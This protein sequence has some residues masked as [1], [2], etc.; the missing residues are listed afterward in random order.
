MRLLIVDDDLELLETLVSALNKHYII[1]T[2][3]TY[4]QGEYLAITNDYDLLILDFNLPDGNGV[5]LCQFLRKDNCRVPILML[6]GRSEVA[7]KVIALDKGVDDYLLKPFSSQ[8]LLARIRALLRRQPL[9]V[10]QTELVLHDL[11]INLATGEVLQNNEPINLRP[12]EFQILEFLVRNRGQI[13]KRQRLLDHLWQDTKTPNTNAIDVH[14]KQLRKK[15]NSFSSQK[16]IV[17]KSIYGLG[18]QLT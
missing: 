8:E 12:K 6:T 2:A 11:T 18:Y 9:Q 1:D 5:E 7:D 14:I 4:E 13:V 3:T 16:P 15:I 17:I 10:L